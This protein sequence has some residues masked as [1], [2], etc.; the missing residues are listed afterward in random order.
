MSFV[1]YLV[2]HQLYDALLLVYSGDKYSIAIRE[3]EE[4]TGV[5]PS[6]DQVDEKLLMYW[7]TDAFRDVQEYIGTL[8]D[9]YQ[10]RINRFLKWCIGTVGINPY[11]ITEENLSNW[12]RSIYSVEH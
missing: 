4:T 8:P 3:L 2:P 9:G 10:T 7:N 12:T 6:D 5:F 1:K 11:E